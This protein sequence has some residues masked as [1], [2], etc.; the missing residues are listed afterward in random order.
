M[1]TKNGIH[2]IDPR[3]LHS[4]VKVVVVGAGG[5][6]S[7]MAAN[8]AVLHQS[9][10]D[11]GH[12]DG[13][14]VTLIDDDAV[15]AANV[16]RARF[17]L[18][19]IGQNKAFVLANRINACHGQGF[20]AINARLDAKA[21]NSRV[22][23]DADIVIGCVDT[24]KSRRA[25]HKALH[26]RR[27]KK[28]CY[29]LDLGNGSLDGQVL[30]GEVGEGNDLLPCVTALYPEMLDAKQ[31]P[32]DEGPSC[33][34]AEALTKQS[35]FVNASAAIHAVSM[36]S[37]LFW[38]GQID[39]CGVFFNMRTGRSSTITCQPEAWA[40]LMEPQVRLKQVRASTAKA[41]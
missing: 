33:S 39:H 24:R 18:S 8:L 29:W 40:R 17:Y 31:D 34:R 35:A 2:F 38:H 27:S 23:Q 7:H 20:R 11:L 41:A 4:A 10:K 37:V 36:L 26:G 16:G 21:G 6:G 13:L 32:K 22:M 5:S 28:S 19:D 3:L 25:I 9:M 30:L 12:P 1:S 15:S 14:E